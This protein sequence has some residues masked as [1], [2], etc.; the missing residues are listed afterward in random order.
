MSIQE[1][2][3]TPAATVHDTTRTVPQ[4]KVLRE[5]YAGQR[6]AGS[7]SAGGGASSSHQAS[8]QSVTISDPTMSC[9]HCAEP[10]ARKR[11]MAGPPGHREA[12]GAE[13]AGRDAGRG[14]TTKVQPSTEEEPGAVVTAAGSR[15]VPSSDEWQRP[16]Q[17]HARKPNTES[18][19]GNRRPGGRKHSATSRA[20]AAP[21]TGADGS[22]RQS[23][24]SVTKRHSGRAEH[25]CRRSSDGDGAGGTVT[26]GNVG[27]MP[28]RQ[29][30]RR[31]G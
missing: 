9:G 8:A 3:I 19:W 22:N 5:S 21:T 18:D 14:R 25:G 11:K 6:A 4:P 30:T 28:G 15:S 24:R 26:L 1:S 2:R 16:Q 20:E 13:N 23:P 31:R 10:S 17:R 7:P 27:A 29:W 12:K